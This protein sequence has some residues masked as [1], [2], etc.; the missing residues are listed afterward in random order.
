MVIFI[1]VA[2]FFFATKE[3]QFCNGRMKHKQTEGENKCKG[4]CIVD[5]E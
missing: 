4:M 2:V 5:I 1:L 3:N